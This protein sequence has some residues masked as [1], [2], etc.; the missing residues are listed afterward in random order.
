MGHKNVIFVPNKED[1]PATLLR[2]TEPGDII[3]TLGA[4]D[5]WKYGEKFVELY[6]SEKK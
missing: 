6:S 4:G 2:I 3:V 1:V 5:I